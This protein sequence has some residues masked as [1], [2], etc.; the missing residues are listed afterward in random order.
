[1]L[2]A[3]NGRRGMWGIVLK[4]RPVGLN[5]GTREG[6]RAPGHLDEYGAFSEKGNTEGGA[7]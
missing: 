7:G 1:M 3:G 4:L 6:S 5:V 2:G